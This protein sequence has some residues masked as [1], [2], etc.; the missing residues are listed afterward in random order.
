MF[1]AE[2]PK[3]DAT[4]LSHRQKQRM[5]RRL[6]K[7]QQRKE[8]L[9]DLQELRKLQTAQKSKQIGSRS[10]NVESDSGEELESDEERLIVKNN[11]KLNGKSKEGNKK[12][13][14]QVANKESE[15]ES[16][17]GNDSDNEEAPVKISNL[18]E[19]DD[20]SD[21]DIFETDSD[22]DDNEEDEENDDNEEDEEDEDEDEMLPIE[23]AGKKLRIKQE[24]EAK[25]AEKEFETSVANQDI[26]TFP[27][28]EN[29]EN[30]KTLTLQDIQQR[31]KDVTLVLSDF[32]KYRQPDRSRPEYLNL[33]K[34]DLCLYYSYNE[35][36][37]E[38]LMD[39]FPLTELMEFLEAS[40]THR[41][42]TIR[43]NS[44]KTRRR[45]LAAALISRGVNLDPLGKW[46]KVGLVIYSS[47]VPLGA[48]PEYLAGHYM[49]QGNFC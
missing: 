36:L 9:K 45:D 44:L 16:E 22:D 35:F 20:E 7:K 18:K 15:S 25:L 28:D 21:N 34:K 14:E 30:Q 10:K 31:I 48:T 13:V 24:K 17:D 46:T 49:I 29:E 12:I 32:K 8:E 37:M 39:I 41:P 40:E 33:L 3:K 47:Q 38:K 11:S 2:K 4:Q 27:D 23:K 26:F 19:L 5:A 43:S 1:L 42:L 6:K